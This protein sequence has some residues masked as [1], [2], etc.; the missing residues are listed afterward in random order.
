MP[1]NNNKPIKTKTNSKKNTNVTVKIFIPKFEDLWN[2]HPNINGIKKACDEKN[3]KGLYLYDNQC[4]INMHYCFKKSEVNMA[5]FKGMKCKHGFARG[6][7]EMA[8]WLRYLKPFGNILTCQDF[9]TQE[10]IDKENEKIKNENEKIKI[11]NENEKNKKKMKPLLA[12]IKE[13][14]KNFKDEIDGKTGIIFIK[15]FW[16]RSNESDQNRSGD[17]IDLWNKDKLTAS[18]MIMHEFLGFIP[19]TGVTRYSKNKEVWFWEMN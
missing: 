9:K 19:F 1:K 4:A 10:T 3:S 2:N 5:S 12:E 13:K 7:E 15:D 18:S 17:H 14:S 16:M 6:A 8:N 11:K